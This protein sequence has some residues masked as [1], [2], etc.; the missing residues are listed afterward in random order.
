MKAIQIILIGFLAFP[1]KKKYCGNTNRPLRKL[2]LFSVNTL[3]SVVH[4]FVNY[5]EINGQCCERQLHEDKE[6]EDKI[7]RLEVPLLI[8]EV[9]YSSY[10][11]V[12][13]CPKPNFKKASLPFSPRSTP[14]LGVLHMVIVISGCSG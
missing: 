9:D 11:I 1:E 10:V 8:A 4:I 6:T 2:P 5:H 7:N 13:R 3:L 12:K 14:W